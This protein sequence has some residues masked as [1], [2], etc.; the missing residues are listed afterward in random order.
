MVF[1]RWSLVRCQVIVSFETAAAAA[2][3]FYK[4]GLVL[5]SFRAIRLIISII[6]IGRCPMLICLAPL[7]RMALEVNSD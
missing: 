7:E 2:N 1:S 4:F 5:R 3:C 6:S